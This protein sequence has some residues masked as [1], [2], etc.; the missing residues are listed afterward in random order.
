MC[1]GRIFG[2][3]KGATRQVMLA[4]LISIVIHNLDTID[5]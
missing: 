2:K 3:S 5:L 4:C 1:D